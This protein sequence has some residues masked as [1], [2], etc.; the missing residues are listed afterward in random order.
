MANKATSAQRFSWLKVLSPLI[1]VFR[2][3]FV[4]TPLRI[5]LHVKVFVMGFNEIFPLW[6]L[7][8]TE[9]GGLDWTV[10]KIGKVM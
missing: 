7:T 1:P 5:F 6:A 9:S 4:A 10:A 8:T 2:G 3:S